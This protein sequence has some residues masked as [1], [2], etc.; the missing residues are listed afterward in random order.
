[1]EFS[2]MKGIFYTNPIN[3]HGTQ[4]TENGTRQ[5]I[6]RKATYDGKE[7]RKA[8]ALFRPQSVPLFSR[9]MSVSC[10]DYVWLG[11]C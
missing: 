8:I 6:S 1:M 2:N 11:L 4:N 3:F 7:F 9:L 10:V 5:R